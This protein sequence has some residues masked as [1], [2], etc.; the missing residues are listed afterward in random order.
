MSETHATADKSIETVRANLLKTHVNEFL[1][2]IQNEDD[3]NSERTALKAL[4]SR[5]LDRLCKIDAQGLT[6]YF[7]DEVEELCPGCLVHQT[8]VLAS[9]KLLASTFNDYLKVDAA[10]HI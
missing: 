7:S 10:D 4:L 9:S 1:D 6:E 3:S 2:T 5:S 8:L